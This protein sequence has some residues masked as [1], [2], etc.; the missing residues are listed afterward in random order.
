MPG[1]KFLAKLV[2]KKRKKTGL[3]FWILNPR[4]QNLLSGVFWL[5]EKL[6]WG[7]IYFFPKNKKVSYAFFFFK[8]F[9]YKSLGRKT[10]GG[11]ASCCPPSLF[12]RIKG[13]EKNG[14]TRGFLARTGPRNFILPHFFRLEKN[15]LFRMAKGFLGGKI[16]GSILNKF[17]LFFSERMLFEGF[18][19]PKTLKKKKN[20]EAR[21]FIF[22]CGDV[23]RFFL[24]RGYFGCGR[25]TF[26]QVSSEKPKKL[27]V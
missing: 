22:F 11:A 9:V 3:F 17:K 20:L 27:L 26:S 2:V 23:L 25:E 14:F 16:F 8:G 10:A 4:E 19:F 12:E 7:V 1:A 6:F 5:F 13:F 15:P 18:N 21:N 24:K